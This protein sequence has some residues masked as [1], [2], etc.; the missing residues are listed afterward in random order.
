MNDRLTAPRAHFREILKAIPGLRPAKR[1]VLNVIRWIFQ[2]T[3]LRKHFLIVD[4]FPIFAPVSAGFVKTRA[5]L[6]ILAANQVFPFLVCL[7]GETKKDDLLGVIQAESLCIGEDSIKAADRLER[8]FCQHGSDKASPHKYHYIYGS[9][10]RNPG[11]ITSMLEIGLGTNNTDVVS[12][13]GQMGRP[14]ASLRAFRDFLPNAEIYGADIDKRILFKEERIS[15]FFVDQTDLNS[16]AELDANVSKKFDL[17]I[18]DGLHSPNANI[19]VL[20]FAL[21]RLKRDGWLVIEDVN[22]DALPVWQVVAAL[23]PGDFKPYIIEARVHLVFAIQ[24]QCEVKE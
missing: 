23:L 20:I 3:F 24:K 2:K 10:L 8:L 18:D 6:T 9:I 22:H 11:S 5:Q 15:T 19:A 12:N 17:I 21:T 7:I 4:S 1:I 14:G 13:M 16:F